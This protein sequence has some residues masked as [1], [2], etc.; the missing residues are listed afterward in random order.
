MEKFGRTLRGYDP[1]EVNKFIDQIIQKIES[2]VNEIREKDE[3]ISLLETI[4]KDY[5][6]IKER[7]DQY[8]KMEETLNRAILM[9]ERTSEQIK[10]SAHQER[11]I[12]TNDAK[13]NASRIINEALIKAEKIERDTE[14][15][16][17]NI[18]I[19]KRRIRDIIETQLSLVDEL[20]KTEM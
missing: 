1:D 11:E 13:R 7:A 16:Q 15:L 19:F 8:D 20:D 2:M 9:A 12:I 18:S 10:L 14:I 4:E 17:R 6:V 5:L 3:K